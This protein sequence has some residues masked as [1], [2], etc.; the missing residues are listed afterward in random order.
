MHFF[1]LTIHLSITFPD[2]R[3]VVFRTIIFNSQTIHL[4]I[5]TPMVVTKIQIHR[6][7]ISSRMNKIGGR[8]WSSLRKLLIY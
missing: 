2:N 5:F 8:A 4:T 6:N 3:S 1:K 7:Q